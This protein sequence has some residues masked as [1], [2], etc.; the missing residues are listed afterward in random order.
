MSVN[1]EIN[2][3][4]ES[5]L[6]L[7]PLFAMINSPRSM[8]LL[9]FWSG[10]PFLDELDSFRK[11]ELFLLGETTFLAIIIALFIKIIGKTHQF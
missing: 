5:Q 8:N 2:R 4:F 11:L 9:S 1:F 10:T 3:F 6:E 7:G